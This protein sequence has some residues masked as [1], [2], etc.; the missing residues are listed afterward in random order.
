MK[1]TPALFTTSDIGTHKRKVPTKSQMV[2]WAPASHNINPELKRAIPHLKPG[3][4]C[5]NRTT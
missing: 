3:Y 1:W 4:G 2:L 5:E